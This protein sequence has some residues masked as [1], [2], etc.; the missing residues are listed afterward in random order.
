MR[1]FDLAFFV[2]LAAGCAFA[3]SDR[4]T[5][6]SPAATASA[7]VGGGGGSGG[8]G[9]TGGTAP[10][11]ARFNAAP[12]CATRPKDGAA[13]PRTTFT[14]AIRRRRKPASATTGGAT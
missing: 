11:P 12:T 13:A 5:E 6:T 14:S 9:G 3:E 10:I 1:A 8:I 7:S 2:S 4:Q